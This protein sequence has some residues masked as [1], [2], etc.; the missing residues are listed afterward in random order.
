MQADCEFLLAG[1]ISPMKYVVEFPG[2]LRELLALAKMLQD[3]MHDREA[4]CCTF[5]FQNLYKIQEN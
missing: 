3:L 1:A 5:S 2:S 4:Y